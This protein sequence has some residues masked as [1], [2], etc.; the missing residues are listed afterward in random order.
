MLFNESGKV[1]LKEYNKRKDLNLTTEDFFYN[2]FVPLFFSGKKPLMHAGNTP[3]DN[4]YH[5]RKI[6]NQHNK[7]EEE[8]VEIAPFL[9]TAES[10]MREKVA[11]QKY[12]MSFVIGGP[13]LESDSA[14]KS[15]FSDIY[16]PKD[17]DFVY[18]TWIGHAL[19]INVSGGF[20]ISIT[21][22][23]IIWR[24]FEGWFKYR[25]IVDSD[26]NVSGNKINA[27]NAYWL[28]YND[29]PDRILKPKNMDSLQ[30]ILDS[31]YFNKD[32]KIESVFWGKM[33]FVI[34]RMTD[35]KKLNSYIYSLG[36]MN[37]TIGIIPIFLSNFSSIKETYIQLFGKDHYHANINEIEKMYCGFYRSLPEAID[38]GCI[39]LKSLQPKLDDLDKKEKEKDENFKTLKINTY[40]T[41]IMEI[42][43]KKE[44]KREI[45]DLSQEFAEYLSDFASRNTKKMKSTNSEKKNFIDSIFQVRS[46]RGL[47]KIISEIISEDNESKA[48]VTKLRDMILADSEGNENTQMFIY[49][50]KIEYYIINN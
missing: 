9:L 29:N 33:I 45:L 38:F 23:E 50:T 19:S 3:Y 44:N 8:R 22:S 36:Q 34:G 7:K 18:N 41:W 26:A 40:K 28:Y 21:E 47:L 12:D 49:L 42:L 5:N 46:Q 32:G 30:S 1:L 24:I 37:K 20:C 4:K 17:F 10:K 43:S 2:V 11:S 14:T 48:I 31:E 16:F 35:K 15:Q 6:K 13:A 25:E 39:N 27:W